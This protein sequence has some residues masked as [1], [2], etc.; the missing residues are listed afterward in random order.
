MT[1]ATKTIRQTT[2]IIAKS[3]ELYKALVDP[4]THSAFTGAKATGKPRVGGAFT[5]WDGYISGRYLQLE[6]GK[7]I[8]REWRT[9]E[10][11]ED[12]PPSIVEFT[13][14]QKKGGTEL[15]MVHSRIPADQAESYRQGWTD[16][17]WKP[18]KEYFE[19]KESPT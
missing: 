19:K 5:A 18:L 9:T 1:K 16:F 10:W 14:K 3:A 13:F 8:V 15:T 7:R 4:K 6:K 12:S 2:V 11:P 17:Y